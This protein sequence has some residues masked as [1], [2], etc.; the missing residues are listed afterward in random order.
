MSIAEA[1]RRMSELLGNYSLSE[2][3]VK[4]KTGML[5]NEFERGLL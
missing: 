2:W 3:D 1:A 4:N 5:I